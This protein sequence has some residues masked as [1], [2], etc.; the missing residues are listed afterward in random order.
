MLKLTMESYK[1]KDKEVKKSA[2]RDKRSFVE[3][4]AAETECAAARGGLSTV[5]KITKRFCGSYTNH[6]QVHQQLNSQLVI[7]HCG[8]VMK[9]I[10]VMCIDARFI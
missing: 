2:R 3:G 4:L 6:D 9:L 8:F 7:N 5:H 10:V 1:G